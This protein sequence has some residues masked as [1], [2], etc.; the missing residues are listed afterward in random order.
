[1]FTWFRQLGSVQMQDLYLSNLITVEGVKQRRR[2][3]D[4]T[5]DAP[6]KKSEHSASYFYKLKIPDANQRDYRQLNVCR[7]AFLAIL[8][9][10][11]NRLRLTQKMLYNQKR[12]TTVTAVV[13]DPKQAEDLAVPEPLEALVMSHIDNYAL[14]EMYRV[15]EMHK[16]FLRTFRINVPYNTYWVIFHAKWNIAKFNP[17]YTCLPTFDTFYET[18]NMFGLV[19]FGSSD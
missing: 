7:V 11:R 16:N 10:S 18:L 19:D 13:N 14:S 12:P 8:G 4:R 3:I 6:G 1:M 5:E 2:T 9:I 15:K 17:R